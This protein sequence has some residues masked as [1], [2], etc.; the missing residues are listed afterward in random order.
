[1]LKVQE[2]IRSHG[3]WKEILSNAPYF[4][5]ISEDTV[6]D[7]DLVL[8]KYSQTES[9]FNEDIVRECRGL[10]LDAHTFDIVCFPF[11]KFFN[12]GEQYAADVDWSTAFV[13]QKLDGSISKIVNMGNGN[14]LLST[15]GVINAFN[16]KLGNYIGCE[17]DSFGDLMLEG[18]KHYGIKVSDFPNLF[19]EGYT[20]IFELTSPWNQVVV[21]WNETK[22][23]F[24]GC[25][26]NVTGKEIKFFEHELSNVF[27]TPKI[28]PITNID[29]CVAAAKELPDNEE[30]YVVCDA[31][32]NRVKVKSPK[33]VQLHYMAGNQNWSIPR[34]VEIIRTNEVG[35]YATYFPQFKVAYDVVNAKYME[36]IE[37][38]SKFQNEI[39]LVVPAFTN[40]KD[41]ALWVM[42]SPERKAFQGFA[43]QYYNH[44]VSDA[45]AWVDELNDKQIV[46]YIK[47]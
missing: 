43:F 30:G 38:V 21:R 22:M 2:F 16:C 28:Y 23:N 27:D 15:N 3:D 41:F 46:E 13:S 24:I 45:K 9:D 39:D 32:F 29:E 47:V 1:M 25:R 20:Y 36:L 37:R 10:I 8:L 42:D 35:E 31:N 18:F 5:S 26:D 12:F 17:F 6:F 14:F 40:K 7:R 19:K 4:I 11:V 33:Y 34:I 44:K